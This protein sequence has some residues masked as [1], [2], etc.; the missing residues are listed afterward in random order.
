MGEFGGQDT[1]MSADHEPQHTRVL[2]DGAQL[3]AESSGTNAL[4][5]RNVHGP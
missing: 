1:A 5:A 2:I 4:K 3:L